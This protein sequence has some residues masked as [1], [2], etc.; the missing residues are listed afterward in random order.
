MLEFPSVVNATQCVIEVQQ[1]MADSNEGIHGD[2]CIGFRI[3]I[4]L[5]DNIIDGRDILG[6]GIEFVG[7]PHEIAK[8]GGIHQP[9]AVPS[10]ASRKCL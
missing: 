9:D 3:G 6:D 1:G 2:R 5:G 8:P 10:I 7:R 4:N